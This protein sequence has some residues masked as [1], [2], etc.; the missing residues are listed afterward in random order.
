MLLAGTKTIEFRRRGPGRTAVG[1]PVLLYASSPLSSLVGHGIML[2]CSR[3]KPSEL[4]ERYADQGGIAE[5]DFRAY[6]TG[7]IFGEAL[8]LQCSPLSQEV[9]LEAL[10]D[11]YGWR[12]PMSWSWLVASSPLLT[13]I[14]GRT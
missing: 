12:P 14:P 8:E 7:A 11:R 9:T 4:W 1:R 5:Q 10:R 2:G 3:A 6:F 13:L